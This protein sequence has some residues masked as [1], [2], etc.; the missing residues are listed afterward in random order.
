MINDPKYVISNNAK[1]RKDMYVIV[2]LLI[3]AICSFIN[4]YVGLFS[5]FTIAEMIILFC[6]DVNAYAKIKAIHKSSEQNAARA[7]RI[8]KAAKSLILAECI[9]S[10]LFTLITAIVQIGV[11][12]LASGSLTGQP[13][14]MTPVNLIPADD[15][16]LSRALLLAGIVFQIIAAI[17][18][19]VRK[20]QLSDLLKKDEGK[21]LH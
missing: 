11:W 14:R 10:V 8:Q 13:T 17:L 3:S 4:P 12:S 5:I 7:T 1:R 16:G 15:P 20:K 21:S 6:V 19:F 9:L 18:S 2:P